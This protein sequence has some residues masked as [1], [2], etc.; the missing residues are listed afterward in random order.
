VKPAPTSAPP[1][2]P[3]TDPLAAPEFTTLRELRRAFSIGGLPAERTPE[4]HARIAAFCVIGELLR[5]LDEFRR[6]IRAGQ[7][8]RLVV[9]EQTSE[10]GRLALHVTIEAEP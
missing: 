1:P 2:R 4:A 10:P 8:C 5:L 6:R 7:R 9:H 3:T